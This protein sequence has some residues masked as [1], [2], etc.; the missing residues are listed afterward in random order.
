M[1]EFEESL[2]ENLRR[3][4]GV[5]LQ[6]ED[7]DDGREDGEEIEGRRGGG[8]EATEGEEEGEDGE[9]GDRIRSAQSYLTQLLMLHPW[10]RSTATKLMTLRRHG[11]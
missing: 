5:L 10:S 4:K 8:E 1:K 11:Y 3:A 6:N 2:K 7:E 9:E